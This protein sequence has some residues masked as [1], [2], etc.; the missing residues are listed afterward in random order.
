MVGLPGTY[1]INERVMM[2]ARNQRFHVA[3]AATLGPG[4]ATGEDLAHAA[5]LVRRL[6]DQMPM[7][8]PAG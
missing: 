2:R 8:E 5:M 7:L 4:L 1:L 3:F 6:Q